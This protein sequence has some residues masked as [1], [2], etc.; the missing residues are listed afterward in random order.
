MPKIISREEITRLFEEHADFDASDF[1]ENGKL[2]IQKVFESNAMRF[3]KEVE[4]DKSGRIVRLAFFRD[5]TGFVYLV[6][7]ENGLIKIGITKKDFEARLSNL[8]SISPVRLELVKVE[9]VKNA[10]AVEKELHQRF[11]DNR[12]H[13]EWFDLLDEDLKFAIDLL[14]GYGSEDQ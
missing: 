6:R 11:E 13:G 8:R 2:N 4:V 3:I 10:K 12:Q 7:A 1:Y 14:N 5:H 9:W